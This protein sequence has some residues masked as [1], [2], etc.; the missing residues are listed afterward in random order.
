[1]VDAKVKVGTVRKWFM[2]MW[3]LEL[4]R[5]YG[6]LPLNIDSHP[7][8]S[9]TVKNAQNKQHHTREEDACMT[10][11]VQLAIATHNNLK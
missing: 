9:P 2:M 7:S 6:E 1:V 8:S 11:R 5:I 10:F 3:L 4:S